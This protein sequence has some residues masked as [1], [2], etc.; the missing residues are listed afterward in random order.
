MPRGSAFFAA[1]VAFPASLLPNPATL[2]RALSALPHA[3][4]GDPG[5][6]PG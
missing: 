4:Y 3:A 5:G 2:M 1:H 6:N